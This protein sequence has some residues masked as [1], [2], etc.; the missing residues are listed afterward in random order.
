MFF[1]SRSPSRYLKSIYSSRP[2]EA[3]ALLDRVLSAIA[4][5]RELGGIRRAYFDANRKALIADDTPR[6]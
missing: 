4:T 1:P 2:G 5:A 3:A 6:D